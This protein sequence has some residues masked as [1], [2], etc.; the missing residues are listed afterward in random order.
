MKGKGAKK[1]PTPY[2]LLGD[3]D[4]DGEDGKPSWSTIESCDIVDAITA[5]TDAGAIISFSKTRDGNLLKIGL[6]QN[7]TPWS[8][9]G[10][11]KE[12]IELKLSKILE[13]YRED[14]ND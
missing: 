2:S 9:F 8:W 10:H 12:K 14:Q 5:A 7:N 4:S 11:N 6:W 1:S 13:T 3:V